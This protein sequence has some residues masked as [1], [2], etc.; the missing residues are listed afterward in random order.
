MISELTIRGDTIAI[1]RAIKEEGKIARRAAVAAINKSLAIA[2]T[3]GV[4]QLAR[5]KALPARV[6][7]SRTKIY[8]ASLDR[9]VGK[10]IALT[11]GLPIDRLNYRFS[12]KG[13]AAAGRKFPHAFRVAKASGE[14]PSK[15]G[16]FERRVTGGQRVPRFPI[17]PVKIDLNP[18]AER[19]FSAETARAGVRDLPRLFARELAYRLSKRR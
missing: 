15:P 4:R 3:A 14:G 6:L 11:A 5:A 18:E 9:L 13:V 16:I 8:K 10:L 17:D 7:K 19:I 1:Q 2:Q 12:R